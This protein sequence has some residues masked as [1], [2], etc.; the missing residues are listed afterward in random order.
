MIDENQVQSMEPSRIPPVAPDE[1]FALARLRTQLA[2]DRT[3]LAWI[4]TALSMFGFGFGMIA[5]FRALRLAHPDEQSAR[6]HHI[7]IGYGIALL[8]LG[9]VAML[10]AGLSYRGDMQRLRRGEALVLRQRWLSLSVALVLTL[11]ALS[12]LFAL[13]VP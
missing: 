8:I 5:F 10:L 11:L 3:L 4:R 12:G 2:L 7:A 9:L 1:R 6:L 13:W